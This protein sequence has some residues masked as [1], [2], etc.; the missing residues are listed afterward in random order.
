MVRDVLGFQFCLRRAAFPSLVLL[1]AGSVVQGQVP[2]SFAFP[3][4]PGA[5]EPPSAWISGD[6]HDHIQ[7]CGGVLLTGLDVLS[8]MQTLA[9]DVASV[10]IWNCTPNEPYTKHVCKV[11][12]TEDPLST[13]ENVFQY[14]V[15]TS[16]FG[17][18]KWGHFIGLDIGPDEAR[19]AN[20]DELLGACYTATNPLNL[21]CP[22]PDGTGFYAA[23]VAR[24]FAKNPNAVRGYAHQAWTLGIYHP[25]GYD[26]NTKLLA[27]GFTTDAKVL[28]PLQN[29]A[30]PP[31][32]T[33]FGIGKPPGYRHIFPLLGPVDAALG[34]IEFLEAADMVFDFSL[35]Q[36]VPARWWGMYYKLLDAGLRVSISGGS[37]NGC[38]PG[39]AT[40][41][42]PRAYVQSPGGLSYRN[43]VQGL[44]AG[45]V[46]LTQG[47]DLYLGLTVEGNELGSNV[48][49]SSPP[50]I[51][52][53]ATLH[54]NGPHDDRIDLLFNGQ[55]I[56]SRD[57]SL[58]TGGSI[59]VSF[60]QVHVPESGWI[61]ATLCSEVA[62]TAATFVYLD[63]RPIVDALAAEYWMVWCD[64]V[65]KTTVEQSALQPFGCQKV[66]V[67][68]DLAQARGVFKSLRDLELGFDSTWQ[69]TRLGTSTPACRGPIAVGTTGPARSGKGLTL[70]CL[71]A[72]PGASGLVYVASAPDPS[73]TGTCDPT[74]GVRLF[75]DLQ[76]LVWSPLP[77][78][79]LRNGFAQR[80]EILPQV[81][82]GTVFYVQ[83]VWTNPPG[84]DE[85]GC[86]GQ[87][88]GYSA[89]DALEFVV[90]P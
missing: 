67:L 77:I 15:E 89:S 23:P 78:Q 57:V 16:G 60:G 34:N 79:S 58:P 1:F 30:F 44:S 10:L 62:H 49:V 74:L 3:G 26:W 13:P 18:S 22:G 53:D 87:S 4:P 88:L 12:G 24:F 6:S 64:A 59:A 82:T 76:T 29:L 86:D 32:E 50:T 54:A 66:E 85:P 41:E 75:V 17:T 39:V 11:T 36:P 28:D 37:D 63:D 65:A 73:P 43:W 71:N 8:R 45:R 31:L 33:L 46:T 83:M 38:R 81:P 47:N 80:K 25:E 21:S 48:Y 68:R 2:C 20:A 70:T 72:P 61:A 9:L 14:A 56:D 35:G 84:C 69:V 90:V 42:A 27:S 40:P 51:S 52:V 19:I 55:V 7:T 5:V